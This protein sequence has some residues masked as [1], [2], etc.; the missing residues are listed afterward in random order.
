MSLEGLDSVLLSEAFDGAQSDPGGWFWIK[1]V[2]RDEVE[3]LGSGKNG[4]GEMR[5]AAI[6]EPDDSPLFG[7]IRFRRRNVL[8]KYVPSGC[9][10]VLMARSQVHFQ[11]F[12]ERCSPHDS[13]LAIASPAELNEQTLNSNC[14]THTATASISSSSSLRS[15][16]LTDIAENPDEGGDEAAKHGNNNNNNPYYV[17]STPRLDYDDGCGSS[18]AAA[19][20]NSGLTNLDGLA[21]SVVVTSHGDTGASDEGSVGVPVIPDRDPTVSSH[22]LSK[23]DFPSANNL[24]QPDSNEP[25][26]KST[27]SASSRPSASDIYNYYPYVPKVKLGPRPHVEPPNK[28]RPHSSNER[29]KTFPPSSS[30]SASNS[31][32]VSNHSLS[33]SSSSNNAHS[34]SSSSLVSQSS[35][36]ASSLSVSSTFPSSSSSSAAAARDEELRASVPRSVHLPPRRTASSSRNA[37]TNPSLAALNIPEPQLP[38]SPTTPSSLYSFSIY[39]SNSTASVK[40]A[41]EG[42]TPEKQR[43]MKALQLR[44]QKQNTEPETPSTPNLDTTTDSLH[45]NA[46]LSPLQQHSPATA[47]VSTTLA[48]PEQ[49]SSVPTMSIT[50]DAPDAVHPVDNTAVAQTVD[51]ATDNTRS[52]DLGNDDSVPAGSDDTKESHKSDE[53]EESGEGSTEA[54]TEGSASGK[55]DDD[56]VVAEPES[57]VRLKYGMMSTRRKVTGSP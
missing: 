7:F 33:S 15:R 19:K 12:A 28:Q 42:P 43:L 30:S 31:S 27:S 38:P 25:R 18:A 11:L 23:G 4:A 29:S 13:T 6:P 56:S 32:S 48:A 5:E 10:R 26:R 8:V 34:S 41:S 49:L 37:G 46:L 17:P 47:F 45:S 24:S 36:S 54:E 55:G 52:Q 51:D 14:S 9:S 2:S 16:R 20:E 40:T 35:L 21:L 3:L 44:K 22:F 1:Y 39:S 53:T 57:T 50:D